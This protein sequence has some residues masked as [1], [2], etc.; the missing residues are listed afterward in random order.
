MRHTHKRK[1]DIVLDFYISKII[2]VQAHFSDRKQKSFF[3]CLRKMKTRK[4]HTVEAISK[5]NV[6]IVERCK[7]DTPNT[8]INE[9]KVR[10]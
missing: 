2:H 1:R 3:D 4:S 10:K 6:K 7:I 9:V 5:S 8:Q